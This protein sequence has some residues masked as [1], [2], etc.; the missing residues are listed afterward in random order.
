M[1][2]NRVIAIAALAGCLGAIG[3]SQGNYEVQVYGSE[4]TPKGVTMVELHSNFTAS[5]VKAVIGGVLPTEHAEHETLE[6][7]HGFNQ[8]VELGFYQFTSIQSGGSWMWVGTHVRPRISVP[9]RYALPVGLSFSTEIGYQRPNFS[10][11]TWT[12]ELRF[13]A[14][15]LPKLQVFV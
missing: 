3:H 12:C 14:R 2:L 5:G 4:L 7:T 13:R 8:W 9:E 10:L 1:I 11:D 6:I 15:F